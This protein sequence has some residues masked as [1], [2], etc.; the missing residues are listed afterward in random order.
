[1]LNAAILGAGAMGCLYASYLC[2]NPDINLL[3][4]DHKA[5]KV[6]SINKNGLLMIE[7]D[8]EVRFNV[9]AKVS[10]RGRQDPVD[11]LLIF[12]KAHQTYA[13]LKANRSLIGPKT[14]VV[15]LQN[16][17]GNYLEIVK[18]VP[19]DR[20]VIGTSNHNSTLLGSGHFLHAADGKTIIGAFSKD[21]PHV[22]LVR[23]IFETCGLDISVS[24]DVRVL[25][26]RKLLVN[27]SI[28]PLTMLLEVKNGFIQTDRHSWDIVRQIIDE[29]LTVAKADGV[30]F[31][32]EEIL[33]LVR[34]ICVLT[35]S[36]CSSMYQDRI[37]KRRTE[38]DFINGSVVSLARK[39]GIP[40]PVNALL[41]QLVHA[42][43]D[44]LIGE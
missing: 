32:R 28:N 37:H 21:S 14:I 30:E 3:L 9:P 20:I 16:G 26:W 24:N 31:D 25:I 11:I 22:E 13:A 44:S 2:K 35:H 23:S 12:V 40:V 33:D 10:G 15:S 36:G 38:I 17:M 8:Q 6:D 5:D 1:M 27:M 4:L 34:K 19:L 29:G 41:V 42:V 43:E 7:N 39:H 18:F